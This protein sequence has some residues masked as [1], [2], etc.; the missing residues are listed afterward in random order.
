[1]G[2]LSVKDTAIEIHKKLF[3]AIDLTE[4]DSRKQA[5]L[6]KKWVKG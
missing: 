1:V 5:S 6:P 4:S 2:I 3:L